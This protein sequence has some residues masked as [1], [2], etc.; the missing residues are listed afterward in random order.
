MYKKLIKDYKVELAL[1]KPV[2]ADELI[3]HITRLLN[4]PDTTDTDEEED[5]FRGNQTG[6]RRQFFST[7]SRILKNSSQPYRWRRPTGNNLP[8]R[9]RTEPAPSTRKQIRDI[10]HKL[11]GAAARCGTRSSSEV[12]CSWEQYID[13][14]LLECVPMSEEIMARFKELFERLKV[15]FQIR[16]EIADAANNE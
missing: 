6:I 10:V 2:I 8:L 12:A 4:R 1:S 16:E 3:E 13:K 5:I 14:Q 9:R 15:S 7:A 11:H